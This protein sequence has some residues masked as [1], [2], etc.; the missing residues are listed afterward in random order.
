MIMIVFP[1]YDTCADLCFWQ[2]AMIWLCLVLDQFSK[3]V[4]MTITRSGLIPQTIWLLLG[5]KYEPTL[6]KKMNLHRPESMGLY[7]RFEY[8]E[9]LVQLQFSLWPKIIIWFS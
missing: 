4:Y 2:V 7:G 1:L 3:T 9:W 5:L 6:L 8:D